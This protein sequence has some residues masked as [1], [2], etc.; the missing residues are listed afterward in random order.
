MVVAIVSA[1]L[2]TIIYKE[3]LFPYWGNCNN[4]ISSVLVS[5]LGGMV[6]FQLIIVVP[7]NETGSKNLSSSFKLSSV[8]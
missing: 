3:W 5:A 4:Y 2:A 1:E 7:L 8:I 6:I